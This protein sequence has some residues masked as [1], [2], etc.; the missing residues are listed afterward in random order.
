LRY[1]HF[2][3]GEDAKGMMVEVVMV[4]CKETESER[5]PLLPT[6]CGRY[7][8]NSNGALDVSKL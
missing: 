6:A 1:R 7:F 3:T 5:D 4:G 2:D 8:Q